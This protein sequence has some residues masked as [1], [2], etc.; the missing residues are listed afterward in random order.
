MKYIKLIEAPLKEL[1]IGDYV[2]V[3]PFENRVQYEEEQGDMKPDEPEWFLGRVVV[4]DEVST[5]YGVMFEVVARPEHGETEPEA[6]F[7]RIAAIPM[8]AMYFDKICEAEGHEL[9][10]ALRQHFKTLHMVQHLME[11]NLEF[12]I[13]SAIGPLDFESIAKEQYK[14]RLN[15]H[16]E[17]R[18]IRNKHTPH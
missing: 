17:E 16:H 13:D 15:N 6:W 11:G 5:E 2:F 7:K 10:S 1:R 3:S 4:L 14:K 18:G 12:L 9:Y 8:P